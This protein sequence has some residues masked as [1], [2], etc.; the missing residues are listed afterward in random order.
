MLD[1]LIVIN[2]FGFAAGGATSL[3]LACALGVRRRGYRV[4]YVTSEGR[5]DPELEASGVEVLLI[6]GA[7]ITAEDRLAGAV[8]GLWRARSA[9]ILREI[10]DR[11][12]GPGVVYHLH[13]WAHFLSPS[14][15][16]VL[17]SIEHRLALTAHDFFLVCPNGA[18]YD[19][20][21]ERVCELKGGSL[22]CLSTNCDRRSGFDKY[23][24]FT[25]HAFR[26]AAVS[27]RDLEARFVM[28]HPGLKPA[29][30]RAG[31]PEHRIDDIRNPVRPFVPGERVAVEHNREVLF[32]GRLTHEK[33][34]DLAAEAARRAGVTIRFV[35]DGPMREM[36]ERSYPEAIFDGFLDRDSISARARSARVAVMP[37]R[38][39]EP[40]GMV[41]P[42]ALWSGIPTIVSENAFLAPEIEKAGAGFSVDPRDT[43]DFARAIGSIFSKDDLAK[44]MSDCA[45]MSTCHIGNTLS[46]WVDMHIKSYKLISFN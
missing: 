46:D 8:N 4:T 32:V 35:G 29:M 22:A 38:W 45:Y 26:S 33:G 16:P 10:V 39:V 13:N 19:F 43:S 42:E 15:F 27:L 23:W 20:R 12:D 1:H 18:Q 41:A 31:V 5:V 40:Y 25:R 9:K 11:Y 7:P 24:R 6:P 34:P 2:D 37:G 28:I 17:K 21:E 3:A 30:M 36:L 44:E 14:I